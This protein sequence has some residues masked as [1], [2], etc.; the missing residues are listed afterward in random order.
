[1]K[2]SCNP[3]DGMVVA[4]V[5]WGTD[6]LIVND[7]HV[8]M[9]QASLCQQHLDQLWD[10]LNPLLK[11][12]K[13]WFRID[14]PGKICGHPLVACSEDTTNQS[15]IGHEFLQHHTTGNARLPDPTGF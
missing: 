7:K 5:Q 9:Q 10:T 15:E 3:C 14:E 12:N 6:T 2:C 13:A 8:P 11:L 1:M 4:D